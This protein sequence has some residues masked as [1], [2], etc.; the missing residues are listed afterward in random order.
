MRY[1]ESREGLGK[2]VDDSDKEKASL[3]RL[4]VEGAE[5]WATRY[6]DIPLPVQS[7][8]A[9]PTITEQPQLQDLFTQ[10]ITEVKK[11]PTPE[12]VTNYWRAKLQVDGARA[13]LSIEVPDCDWT[14]EEIKRPM[15]DI[16]GNPVSAMMVYIPEQLIGKES[17]VILGKMYPQMGIYSVR[18]DTPITDTHETTGWIKVEATIA[19]PNLNTSQK[20]LEDFAKKQ[21][22]LGQTESTYILASQASKDLNDHY[23]DEGGTSCR[24]LG[25]YGEDADYCILASCS[26][27]RYLDDDA[28]IIYPEDGGPRAG[29]RFEEVIKKSLIL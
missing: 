18:E 14:E 3:A 28:W 21:G 9:R 24:L 15:V 5:L 13:G 10:A 25:S 22:Y 19:A 17:L 27:G 7:A 23:F 8:S 4:M 29:S 16:R 1:I 12:S 11:S 26:S 2:F 6:G 20:E